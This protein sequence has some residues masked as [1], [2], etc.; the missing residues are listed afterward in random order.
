MAINPFFDLYEQNNEQE[1]WNDLVTESIQILGE[2]VLYI[3]RNLINFDRLLGA[4][5]SSR[6]DDSYTIE[7]QVINVM[8]FGGDKEFYSQFGHQVRDELTLS[9]NRER[10]MSE[11]GLFENVQTPQE[12]DLIWIKRYNKLFSIKFVD[13][14]EN[15]YQLGRLY[16]WELIC[17]VFE[18][19]GEAI[20]TGVEEVDD[21]SERSTNVVDW[22]M[23]DEAGLILTDE[24]GNILT[25][26]E[27]DLQTI[28]P[29]STND[30]V[31]GELQNIANNDISTHDPFG[32]LSSQS[33]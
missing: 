15:F 1:L 12:G 6:F 16:T 21:I 8:G 17:E 30:Y 22:A 29:G 14:R 11:V 9:V 5:D 25:V 20:D 7:M 32:F 27:Y 2:D 31:P 10:W 19:S 13:P 4:D 18:Y 33:R 26:D 24:D 28:N 23:T 3:P